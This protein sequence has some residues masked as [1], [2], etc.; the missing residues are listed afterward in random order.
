MMHCS[1]GRSVLRSK[2][3]FVL[4]TL[5]LAAPAFGQLLPPGQLP[6]GPPPQPG[7]LG[8]ASSNGSQ[9]GTD[10]AGTAKNSKPVASAPDVPSADIRVQVHN[11]LVPTTVFDPDGH[12]YVNGL[13]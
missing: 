3:L 2:S 7:Q 5:L 4:A 13:R 11:I 1:A 9:P 6:S 12:G 8:P 10:N